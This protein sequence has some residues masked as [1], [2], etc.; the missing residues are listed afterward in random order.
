MI[1]NKYQIEKENIRIANLTCSGEKQNLPRISDLDVVSEV[2]YNKNK[3]DNGISKYI[4]KE[5]IV[6]AL[7]DDSIKSSLMENGYY[8]C[9]S[10]DCSDDEYI[11]SQKDQNYTLSNHRKPYMILYFTISDNLIAANTRL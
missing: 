11:Q 7:S 9:A 8:I 6:K 1:C 2:I 5:R 3:R 4:I 10:G